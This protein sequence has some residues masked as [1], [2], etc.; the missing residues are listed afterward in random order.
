MIGALSTAS[1]T[2]SIATIQLEGRHYANNVAILEKLKSSQDE[3]VGSDG[4]KGPVDF[5][6]LR[7]LSALLTPVLFSKVD[8]PPAAPQIAEEIEKRCDAMSAQSASKDT[9]TEFVKIYREASG[10]VPMNTKRDEILK[11]IGA[12]Q[13]AVD[14]Y[15]SSPSYSASKDLDSYISFGKLVF[16]WMP[17]ALP[18]ASLP[19]PMLVLIVTV[20]MGALGSLLFMLQLHLSPRGSVSPY[21]S[22]VSWHL[23]RPL[24]GMAAA[25]AIFLLVK[26]GQLSV[27][28]GVGP[29]AGSPS[30]LNVFALG[31]LG[32][33]SGL[34]ADGAMERLSSAGIELLSTRRPT[35]SEVD[36]KDARKFGESQDEDQE[37]GASPG[38]TAT[39]EQPAGMRS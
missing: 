28:S 11:S 4:G 32:V 9:C 37:E 31:L 18:L 1:K 10:V 21:E 38:N 39:G 3:D 12:Y 14:K 8:P 20:S 22:S 13:L 5:A 23:F 7:D 24:Q 16:P 19:H 34:L 15:E 6:R 25:L 27:G 36:S 29:G 35:E 2:V 17:E 33:L 26:A 30:E